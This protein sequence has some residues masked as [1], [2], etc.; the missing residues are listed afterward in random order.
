M[1]LAF[2]LTRLESGL[3]G[4]IQG[5][6][7]DR[8][9][10]RKILTIGLVIFA[11]GFFLFS[12]VNSVPS[13]FVA[14]IFIALG[15]SLGGWAT[16][17]VPIVNWFDKNRAKAI[18]W[19]QLGFSFGGLCV[20]IMAIGL[21]T[22]GWRYMG[23]ISGVV[24]LLLG[25]PLVTLIYHRP[26]DFNQTIDGIRKTKNNATMDSEQT[27]LV[28]S[29]TWREAIRERSFWLISIGH[30]LSLLAVSSM[31]AHLIPHLTNSLNYSLRDASVA[32]SIMTGFQML[33]IFLGG[34]LGDKYNKQKL[35][36]FCM[37]GHFFGLVAIAYAANFY[38]IIVFAV[39]HGVAWG[40]RGP[41]M[42]ALRA[43]FFGPKSFGTIMGFS[44]LIV[45]IGMTLGPIVCGVL[46]DYYGN[47]EVAFTI[48]ALGSLIGGVC[49]WLCEPPSSNSSA[50][51][52]R[53]NPV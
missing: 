30:S 51:L 20:P 32:F 27:K 43:D 38:W 46:F 37:L 45:M 35:V 33:G 52:T 26:S 53:T 10:P 23:V 15:S 3:L 1:S 21:E 48:M 16:L 44:S 29:F 47:Y 42:V 19:S 49:F 41:L 7:V 25:L 39:L 34:Y 13:Y 2:A 36:V 24:I 22:F 31:L 4:P 6:L 17:M 40:I 18:A 9:G 8:Y 11:I 14:F 12:Q 50:E 5:W 28:H